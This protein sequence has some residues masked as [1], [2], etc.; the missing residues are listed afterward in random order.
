MWHFAGVLSLLLAINCAAA[1]SAIT[2]NKLQASIQELRDSIGSWNVQTDFLQ[3]DGT[4]AN[5]LQGTYTFS[6][7]VED[8]VISGQ[9]TLPSINQASAILFYVNEQ[10]QQIEMVSVGADGRLWIMRGPLGG[11]QRETAP[12]KNAQGQMQQLR[13]TRFNNQKDAFESKMEYTVDGGTTWIQ[14]NHQYF[15]RARNTVQ[16]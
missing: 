12:Y 10:K 2:Q 9:S 13:F 4:I 14:G 15:K 7:V 11:N 16:E 5:S 1:E 6:W 3:A 8:R